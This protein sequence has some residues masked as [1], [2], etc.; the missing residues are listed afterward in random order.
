LELADNFSRNNALIRR[1]TKRDNIETFDG[2]RTIVQ[3][4]EY[5]NNQTFQWYSGYQTLLVGRL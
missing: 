1:M 5:A 3:E 4:L 2:G